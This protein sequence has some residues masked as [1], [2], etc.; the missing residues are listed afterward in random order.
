MIDA[1]LKYWPLLLF[2]LQ[3]FSMWVN[4]SLKK[5]FVTHTDLR[6]AVTDAMQSFSTADTDIQTDLDTLRSQHHNLHEKVT[7]SIDK[8]LL[9][10]EEGI[11]HMPKHEDLTRL[12]QRMDEI[13]SQL[14]K[15]GGMV[16]G[17]NH[18]LQLIQQHLLSG[19]SKP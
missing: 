19:G 6:R 2:L 1:I 8:R 15:I 9:R 4:W 12:H 10:V 18:T 5:E 14:Q 16:N 7:E 13:N 11:K 3:F 17:S